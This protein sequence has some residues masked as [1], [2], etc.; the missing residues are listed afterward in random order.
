MNIL[1]GDDVS[2]VLL[3]IDAVSEGMF[4]AFVHMR[5]RALKGLASR[6]RVTTASS[7]AQPCSFEVFTSATSAAAPVVLRA[8]LVHTIR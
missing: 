7:H 5:M 3:C 2:V 8:L 4:S 1:L 6:L